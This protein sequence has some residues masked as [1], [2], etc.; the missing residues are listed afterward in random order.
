MVWF[1]IILAVLALIYLGVNRYIKGKFFGPFQD[2]VKKMGES[3]KTKDPGQM[4]EALEAYK[5]A[6]PQYL[7][8]FGIIL[9]SFFI[10]YNVAEFLDP[11]KADDL[12]AQQQ[13]CVDTIPEHPA[14]VHIK[15]AGGENSTLYPWD[16][17]SAD[18][19][20]LKHSGDCPLT[21][22]EE[23]NRTCFEGNGT[24]TYDNGTRFYVYL[25]IPFMKAVVGA[26]PTFLFFSLLLSLV[27]GK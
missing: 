5:K 17:R 10:L 25:G 27:V 21:I 19:A 18:V 1:Y 14:V 13:L 20:V 22:R 26:G 3:A 11:M 4:K 9:A 7:L 23:G 12:T 6:Y 16:N 15:C 8:G 24:I 2:A